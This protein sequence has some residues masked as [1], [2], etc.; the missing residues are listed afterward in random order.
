MEAVTLALRHQTI[1]PKRPIARLSAQLVRG[2]GE[3]Q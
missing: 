1:T 2:D 3:E